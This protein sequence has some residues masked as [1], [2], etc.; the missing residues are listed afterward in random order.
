MGSAPDRWSELPELLDRLLAQPAAARS[1]M[2]SELAA[3]DD[4]LR[5]E[6]ASLLVV[7][8]STT[9][10]L[11]RPPEPLTWRPGSPPPPT[12]IGAYRLDEE[13]GGGP[14]TVVYRAVHDFPPNHGERVEIPGGTAP[15]TVA[16]KLLREGNLASRR[17]RGRL[18]DDAI[19][20]GYT[21]AHKNL[22]RLLG[23]GL[24]PVPHLLMEYVD[25]PAIDHY[26]DER[27]LSA[28][29]RLE[30]FLG[31]CSAVAHMHVRRI[32]HLD[33][34]PPNVLVDSRGEP[35]VLDFGAM[36][37]LGPREERVHPDVRSMTPLW[38]SPEQL[39][40]GP[41]SPASD[42]F[43]LGLLLYRLLTGAHP[44]LGWA[45][46]DELVGWDRPT[47]GPWTLGELAAAREGPF[48]A[49][50][51]RLPTGADL[52]VLGDRRSAL[53]AVALRA[54]AREPAARP[55][56]VRELAQELRRVLAG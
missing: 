29:Q 6:L 28:M 54:V 43:A 16:V 23:F 4:E 56:S 24:R 7:D 30:L 34:K 47:R 8:D 46:A 48:C 45:E 2:L 42:L 1:A 10:F 21:G 15:G 9:G 17:L 37:R 35:R 32:L 39:A 25:G 14:I 31:V 18:R 41:V 33:L 11:E 44:Y 55:S 27:R 13:I 40:C 51:R 22:L 12:R 36:V 38:A 5:R 3:G 50:R 52:A 26:C 49:R 20:L 53:D 19:A